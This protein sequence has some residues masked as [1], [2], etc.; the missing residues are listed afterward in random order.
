ME[1]LKEMPRSPP[2]GNKF[3]FMFRGMA[4]QKMTLEF[5]DHDEMLEAYNELALKFLDDSQFVGQVSTAK[6][7]GLYASSA[8][9][10]E[11]KSLE[12]LREPKKRINAQKFIQMF[13]RKAS[14]NG[15]E[16]FNNWPRDISGCLNG[17]QASM[18]RSRST[19]GPVLAC[20]A[21]F[22]TTST[23]A[24]AVVVVVAADAAATAVATAAAAAVATATAAVAAAAATAAAAAAGEMISRIDVEET[25]NGSPGMEK[26]C[27]FIGG[28]ITLN[29]IPVSQKTNVKISE[30][31]SQPVEVYPFQ[32][33][34]RNDELSRPPLRKLVRGELLG[35]RQVNATVI[36]EGSGLS[37]IGNTCFMN[38]MLQGLFAVESFTK[39]LFKFCKKVEGRLNLSAVMPMST[40]VS[41]LAYG[42]ERFTTRM[43]NLLLEQLKGTLD[44]DAHEFLAYLMDKVGAECDKVLCEQFGKQEIEERRKENPIR[45]N[46][47]F[48][49][50]DYITCDKCKHVSTK[51]EEGNDISI[52]I[53]VFERDYADTLSVQTLLD[54][55]LK[56]EKIDRACEKCGAKT[57]CKGQKFAQLP[58]CLVVFVKRYSYDEINMKRFDRIHIPKYLTLEGH[59][60]P[61][62]DPTCPAVPDSTK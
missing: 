54:E 9:A 7:R 12:E 10:S 6:S 5:E 34:G 21:S 17:K 20:F 30:K 48:V 53:D 13:K 2:S 41:A 33:S 14:L 42:R 3:P 24:P 29:G 39:D 8:L 16:S 52:S 32:R 1:D 60:A 18:E 4:S 26:V 55:H 36:A 38:A 62:I 56:T 44:P 40:T 37:N 61:G 49:L 27:R 47:T 50:N 59:C 15:K 46:F 45:T 28:K 43:K 25:S 11:A 58:R 22:E 51:T 57:A 31:F 19:I 23:A 35:V